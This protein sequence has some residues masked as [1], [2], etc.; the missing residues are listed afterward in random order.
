MSTLIDRFGRRHNYL[1]ISLTDRCNLRCTYCMPANGIAVAANDKLMTTPEIVTIARLLV[2]RGV[3][4]IRLTGGEPTLRRDLLPLIEQ[5]RGIPGLRTLA[6]TT[7]GLTLAK[8]AR[9]LR[10]AG[11]DDLTVSLDTLRRLRFMEI[12]RRD[13]FA[14]VEAGIAAALAAGFAPLKV[15]AVMMQGINEDELLDFVFL[16]RDQP[17]H[18]RFIEYMPFHGTGWNEAGLL[19]YQVMKARIAAT[20]E[21]TPLITAASAVGRDFIIPGHAGAVGFIT[22]MT[23]SFCAGCN[24]LRLTADGAIKSCLFSNGEVA[25]LPALRAGADDGELAALVALALAGKPE[26]HPPMAELLAMDN[27]T[28]VAIGG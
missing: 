5:L 2:E 27:R 3:D 10:D 18:V 17:I 1:R 21:L 16:T 4:K 13:R 9:A 19:P 7:N 12:T 24:R 26:K 22:S 6:M 8:D 25:L 28:M 23:E 20:Y 11:L 15:N 14:E